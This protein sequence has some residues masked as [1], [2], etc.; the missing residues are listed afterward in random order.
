M[1][2]LTP[3]LCLGALVLFVVVI[4]LGLITALRR[5]PGATEDPLLRSLKAASVGRKA[6]QKQEADLDE[7]H[8]RVEDLQKK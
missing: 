2:K 1:D 4:N 7:L 6:R 5:K 8:R 3:F